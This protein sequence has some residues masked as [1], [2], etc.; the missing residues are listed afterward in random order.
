M[1]RI[2]S[3]GLELWFSWYKVGPEPEIQHPA[4]QMLVILTLEKSSLEYQKFKIISGHRVSLRL[5]WA[6]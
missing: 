5:A 4:P 1:W 3:L 2:V 6:T